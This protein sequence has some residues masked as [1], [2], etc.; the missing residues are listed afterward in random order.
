MSDAIGY[1]LET[2]ATFLAPGEVAIRIIR[3]CQIDDFKRFTGDAAQKLLHLHS[4]TPERD[5]QIILW[6]EASKD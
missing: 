3:D 2:A 4:V 6:A 5:R 1:V